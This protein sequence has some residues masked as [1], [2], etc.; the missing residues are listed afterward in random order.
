MGIL[1]K[2]LSADGIPFQEYLKHLEAWKDKLPVAAYDYAIAKW[3]YDMTD[4]RCIHDAWLLFLTIKET[5]R[6][7][8]ERKSE[9]FEIEASFLSAFESRVLHFSYKDVIQYCLATP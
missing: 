3:H 2:E 7:K 8:P 6:A 1:I 4:S 5:A 9:R